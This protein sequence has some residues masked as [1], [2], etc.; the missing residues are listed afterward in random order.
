MTNQAS[1]NVYKSDYKTEVLGTSTNDPAI[2][3]PE[4]DRL[5]KIHDDTTKVLLRFKI[6]AL[7]YFKNKGTNILFKWKEY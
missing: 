5:K 7:V 3:Y 1:D 6:I 2:A 4:H